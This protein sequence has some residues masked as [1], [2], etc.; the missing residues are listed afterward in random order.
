MHHSSL[1]KMNEQNTANG[2]NDPI[3]LKYHYL[4]TYATLFT[5]MNLKQCQL[6][7]EYQFI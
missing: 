4:F 3:C 7:E 2:F 6:N 5:C 1:A